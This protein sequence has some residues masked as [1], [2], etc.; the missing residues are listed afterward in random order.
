[1][2]RM[3]IAIFSMLLAGPVAAR[4][5][6][7]RIDEIVW[8]NIDSY[9]SF[10]RADHR[11]AYNDPE[12]WRWVLFTN[13]PAEDGV[14][15]IESPFMRIDGQLKQLAQ[16]GIRSLDGGVVRSYQSHDANPYLVEVSLLEG[17]RGVESS[18]F[19]GVIT[20]SRNGASSEI[21]YKGDCG[22]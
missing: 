3:L 13:F 8:Y 20:V 2:T 6:A 11:F 14:D 21:A 1:M 16:T 7:P 5:G 4:D 12:S 19:S 15:P 9:C 22:A 10:T 17:E 18:A